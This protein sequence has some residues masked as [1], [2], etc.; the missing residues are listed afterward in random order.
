MKVPRQSN[1]SCGKAVQKPIATNISIYLSQPGDK[2]L[3]PIDILKICLHWV[4]PR[5]YFR[6]HIFY[7]PA[8]AK[9]ARRCGPCL[10]GVQGSRS[11]AQGL[12]DPYPLCRTDATGFHPHWD[13]CTHS[14]S[15]FRS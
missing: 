10:E 5:Q 9:G 7:R 11:D 3:P 13:R 4:I 15:S 8:A 12:R 1:Y 14:H 6:P 2:T